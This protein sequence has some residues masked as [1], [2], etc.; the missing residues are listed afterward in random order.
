MIENVYCPGLATLTG[1]VPPEL[2]ANEMANAYRDWKQTRQDG[3]CPSCM[4]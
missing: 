3:V 2:A 1:M 4:T